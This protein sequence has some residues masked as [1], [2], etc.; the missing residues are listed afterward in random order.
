LHFLT[1]INW[2]KFTGYADAIVEQKKPFA[3][4]NQNLGLQDHAVV[5]TEKWQA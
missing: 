4:Q 1:K 5:T 3:V 2:G